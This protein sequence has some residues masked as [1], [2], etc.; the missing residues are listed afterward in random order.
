VAIEHKRSNLVTGELLHLALPDIDVWS[1]SVRFRR[2]NRAAPAHRKM[3]ANDEKQSPGPSLAEH[4]LVSPCVRILHRAPASARPI[5]RDPLLFG[6]IVVRIDPSYHHVTL[7]FCG[8]GLSHSAFTPLP[9]RITGDTREAAIGDT[10][11]VL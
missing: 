10:V 11:W 6:H 7:S 8:R 3:T 2:V 4:H 1:V 5:G 9:L